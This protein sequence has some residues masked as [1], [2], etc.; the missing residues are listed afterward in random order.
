MHKIGKGIC[1][2]ITRVRFVPLLGG[3]DSKRMRGVLEKVIILRLLTVDDILRL[4]SDFKHCVAEAEQGRFVSDNCRDRL[5]RANLPIN[6]LERLGLRRLNKHSRRNRPR[7]SR[8]ME[9]IV[10]QALREVHHL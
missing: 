2:L 3:D 1:S 6:F 7:T 10:L 9:S 4:L 5:I 8:G